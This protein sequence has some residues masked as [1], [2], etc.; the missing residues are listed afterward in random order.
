MQNG[1]LLNATI[2]I[3]AGMMHG[4]YTQNRRLKSKMAD[5]P[6]SFLEIFKD[7]LNRF[8]RLEAVKYCISLLEKGIVSAPELYEQILAPSLNAVLVCR[9][10]EHDMIW[11]EHVMTSIVRSVIESAF[12]YVL[13]E[14]EKHSQP[15][16]SQKAMLVCP[17]EEYHD[18]GIRMGADFFAIAGY[19]VTYI[20]SNTPKTNILSAASFLKPDIIDIGVSNYLNLVMLKKIIPE[21]KQSLHYGVRIML[22]GSA[23]RHTGRTYKDFFADGIVNSFQDVL[24]LRGKN[25]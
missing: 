7:H 12:P 11:R 4:A 5:D 6:T 18:L 20:G 21:L 23:F 9:D 2:F 8:D 16:L 24:D 17:E 15:G 19:D 1:R 13:K 3:L 10:N 25:P 14:R 22:S